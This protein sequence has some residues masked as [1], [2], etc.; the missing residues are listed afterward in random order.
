MSMNADSLAGL[1][2]PVAL[3][4]VARNGSSS[5]SLHCRMPGQKA[6]PM[7]PRTRS[8]P[9]KK[10]RRTRLVLLL[11]VRCDAGSRYGKNGASVVNDIFTACVCAPAACCLSILNAVIFQRRW[12]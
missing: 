12:T 2:T 8:G 9:R 5:T 1:A 4:I 7:V 3:V 6:V 11:P 10:T